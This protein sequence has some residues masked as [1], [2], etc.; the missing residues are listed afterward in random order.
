MFKCPGDE[1][2]NEHL[3]QHQKLD[4]ELKLEA[5]VLLIKTSS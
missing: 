4:V 5:I 2:K 3:M 1:I